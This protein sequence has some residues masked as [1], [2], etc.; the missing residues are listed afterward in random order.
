MAKS[1]L[2]QMGVENPGRPVTRGEVA[3]YVAEVILAERR[4]IAAALM[5]FGPN[6]R[7]DLAEAIG[8]GTLDPGVFG[9]R[10]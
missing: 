9:W 4:R 1:F 6:R 5:E 10:D 7:D 3:A 8:D 2:D